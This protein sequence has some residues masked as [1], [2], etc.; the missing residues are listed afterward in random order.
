[1]STDSGQCVN[2]IYKHGLRINF[3]IFMNSF[4]WSK[5]Y[6]FSQVS[7]L[8]RYKTDKNDTDRETN[9]GEDSTPA[10]NGRE[11]H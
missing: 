9:G 11:M 2:V 5:S 8:S 7:E 3:K 6:T 10:E 1:M 4:F